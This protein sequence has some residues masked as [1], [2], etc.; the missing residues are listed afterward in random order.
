MRLAVVVDLCSCKLGTAMVNASGKDSGSGHYRK[1]PLAYHVQGSDS[2]LRRLAQY[3]LR[4]TCANALH[5]LKAVTTQDK[6]QVGRIN[7][8]PRAIS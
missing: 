3:P 1:E 2:D 5:I 8:E 7:S 4:H 6:P